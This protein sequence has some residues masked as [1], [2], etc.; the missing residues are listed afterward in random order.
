MG[1]EQFTQPTQR[2]VRNL[3]DQQKKNSKIETVLTLTIL[4]FT[5]LQGIQFVLNSKY[6]DTFEGPIIFVM[7]IIVGY[8]FYYANSTMKE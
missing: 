2:E 7:T 6:I 4:L 3:I 1:E 5:Y 8:A